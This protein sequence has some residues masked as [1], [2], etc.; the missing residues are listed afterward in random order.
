MKIASILVY[1]KLRTKTIIILFQV[2]ASVLVCDKLRTKTNVFVVSLAIAD[3]NVASVV[4]YFSI[5]GKYND[6]LLFIING[7][8]W[9]H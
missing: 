2:I 3:L 1:D 6:K 9:F 4:Q 7:E 5:V 8:F